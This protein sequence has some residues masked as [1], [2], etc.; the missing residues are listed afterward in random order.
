MTGASSGIGFYVAAELL[1]G[2]CKVVCVARGQSR[3]TEAATALI[4]QTGVD[5]TSVITLAG[6]AADEQTSE[7]TVNA[8]VNT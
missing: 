4:T 3:L 5:A 7:R 2:G 1:S 6:D 8:A